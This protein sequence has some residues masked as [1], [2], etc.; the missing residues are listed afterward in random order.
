MQLLR[1][2][3]SLNI[4]LNLIGGGNSSAALQINQYVKNENIH[5][6]CDRNLKINEI[7]MIKFH[8]F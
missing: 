5:F 2:S 1:V 3:I 6:Y 8:I 4:Y 7:Y